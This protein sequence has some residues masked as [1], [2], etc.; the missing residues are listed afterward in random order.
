MQMIVMMHLI[1][2]IHHHLNDGKGTDQDLLRM[3]ED[4]FQPH[5]A[6]DDPTAL[7]SRRPLTGGAGTKSVGSLVV[8]V[9][10]GPSQS[11]TYKMADSVTN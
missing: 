3:T 11:H 7:V 9:I 5:Q 4:D 1:D 6:H 8:V 2:F 10:L